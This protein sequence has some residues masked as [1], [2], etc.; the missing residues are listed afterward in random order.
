VALKAFWTRSRTSSFVRRLGR[1]FSSSLHLHTIR[2]LSHLPGYRIP[3]EFGRW[4]ARDQFVQYL[5]QY[6]AHHR[7]VPRLE[8]EATRI[9]RDDGHWSVRTTTGTIP[10][11][12]VV[13]ATGYTRLPHLPRWPGTFDGPVIHSVEYRNPQPYRDQDVLIV[14]A[15]NSGTEIAVDLAEGGARRVRIAVRTPPNILRRDVK[16]FPIQLLGIVFRR[17]PPRLLDQLILLLERATVPDLSACGLPRPSAPFSQFRHTGTVPIIDVGFIDAVRSGV[18][19]VVPGVTALDSRAIVLADGSRVFPDA[20]VAATG[21]HP[22]LEPLV[23]HLTAIGEHGIPSPQP[24]LHFIGMRI[25]ISGLLREVG[26][27]ARQIA[28]NVARELG[29]VGPHPTT[30]AK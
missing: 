24:R 2:S 23:G 6:A 21:Y 14:G 9:D 1:H 17:L 16:G 15:G 28:G 18:I 3:R 20:V 10:A 30:S 8:V 7:L 27:D 29:A 12:V 4:V 22:G 25:P 26:L 11:R 5:E 19:E 13:V